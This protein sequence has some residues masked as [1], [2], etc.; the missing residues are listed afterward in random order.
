ML[1]SFSKLTDLAP[2]S[3]KTVIAAAIAITA[4][5]TI[6]Y[7]GSRQIFPYDNFLGAIIFGSNIIV[8]AV[9]SFIIL[10]YV[11][12]TSADLRTRSLLF[13][14]IFKVVTATMLVLIV[15]F[16]AMF[17]GFYYYNV[18]VRY[19]AYFVFSLSTIVSVGIM[20]IIGFK[21]FSW[22]K[23]SRRRDRDTHRLLLVCGLAA[24]S[25]GAAMAFDAGTKI[26]LVRVVEE[27]SP[28]GSIPQDM[29]IYR[30]D[31]K[32]H[33]D[34]QLKVVKPDTTTV[35]IVPSSIKLIFTYL[36]GWIPI[37]V[38][39]VFTWAVITMLLRQYYNQR[40]G[41]MPATLLI[42]LTIPL[43]LYMIGRYTELYTLFSSIVGL[44]DPQAPINLQYGFPNVDLFRIIFRVGVISGSIMYG[45]AFLVVARKIEAG[46][47]KDYFT[48]AAIGAMMI[49]IT[50]GPSGLQ[51][52]FG[53]AGRTLFL[54]ASFMLCAGF[55]LSA[56]HMAQD[57]RLRKVI[58]ASAGSKVFGDMADA[59]LG[60]ETE[61][62]VLDIIEKERE[63]IKE[64]TGIQ[65]SLEQKDVKT[66]LDSVLLEIQ[67]KKKENNQITK[68]ASGR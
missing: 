40:V 16:V 28:P 61:K 7:L 15:T 30:N 33:G 48:F 60:Q 50:L 53:V 26:L 36:N 66:Y 68:G 2:I 29:F 56:V 47:I 34:V 41:K 5:V 54:L 27:E 31:E 64:Q 51:E 44:W 57:A 12:Q 58:K 63:I 45:V 13:D 9:G 37:T 35:Y 14:R 24:A 43:V 39:Y 59:Q 67:S 20:I 46:K 8:V 17:L 49:S 4:V 3:R 55:Y 25:L 62:R 21:F 11:S 32:Y 65:P 6:D 42:L 1:P 18:S 23:L 38:G 52:T 10:K 19:L 22:Y